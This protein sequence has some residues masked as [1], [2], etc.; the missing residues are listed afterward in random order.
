MRMVRSGSGRLMDVLRSGLARSS[1]RSRC[2]GTRRT[3]SRRASCIGAAGLAIAMLAMPA[4]ANAGPSRYVFEMCDSALPG[5]GTAG[6]AY[7]QNPGQPWTKSNTCGLPGGALSITQSGAIG[8]GGSATWALPIESPPGGRMESVA[9][10]A[11]LCPQQGTVAWVLFAGWPPHNCGEENRIFGIEEK[12]RG[13]DIELQCFENCPAGARIYARNFAT[14]MVDPVPP[15]VG[16]LA[17]SLLSGN[18]QRGKQGL[19]AIGHDIGGGI[20]ELGAL[21]NGLPAAPPRVENCAVAQAHNQTVNG[22]VATQISPC[23][24]DASADWTLDTSSFPFRTGPNYV[25]VCASDF[26]TLGDPQTTCSL[27]QTITVDDTCVESAVAGGD[28][29]SAD[30]DA[31][32]AETI[33]VGYGKGAVVSGKLASNAGDPV[34]GATLCVKAATPGMERAPIPVGSVKTDY[35]GRYSYTVPPGPNREIVVGYRHDSNQVAR[36]VRYFARAEPSFTANRSKVKNGSRVRFRGQLPA[37]REAGRVVVLQAGTVGSKRWIT[38][39]RATAN[40]T[41]VFHAA[42]RF[43]STMRR[44]RYKFRA[45]VPRQPGYPYI[46]GASKAAAVLVRPR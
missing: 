43:R 1:K 21:I 6:V 27:P 28:Q 5:G 19:S 42:Y 29:L 35:E 11:Y 7:S 37:P 2:H 4:A 8:P 24:A 23:P 44:T 16:G 9:V 32:N 26:A 31:S 39:R 34:P 41:G 15:S 36:E 25:Q 12:Y 33:T 3:K 14:T 18:V 40:T 10:T 22:T 45:V 46:A 13:F 30:F 20:S 38:F 17:G